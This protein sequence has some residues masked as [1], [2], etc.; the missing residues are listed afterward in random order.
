MSY[1]QIPTRTTSDTNSPDDVN[2]LQDNFDSFLNTAGQITELTFENT[3]AT[4]GLSATGGNLAWKGNVLTYHYVSFLVVGSAVTGD[5][6]DQIL[7]D[8]NGTLLDCRAHSDIAPAGS[9]MQIQISKNGT[10]DMLSTAI[11]I[12]A[13][14]TADDG[15]KV[16]DT[17]NDDFVAGDRLQADFDQVGSSTAGGNDTTITLKVIRL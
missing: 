15:N 1:Q 17:A 3:T 9:S 10:V 8:F 16:I 13:G 11:E 14:A 2:Q 12:D 4:A 5:K 7:M 6:Q